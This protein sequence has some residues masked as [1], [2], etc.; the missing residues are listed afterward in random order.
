[1]LKLLDH[2]VCRTAKV[3]PRTD[4]GMLATWCYGLAWQQTAKC[5]LKSLLS[6]SHSGL[7]QTCAGTCR[8][9]G[10]KSLFTA[11]CVT[12]WRL[13]AAVLVHIAQS[14]PLCLHLVSRS[15]RVC[16]TGRCSLPCAD[17]LEDNKGFVCGSH[18]QNCIQI[19]QGI[20]EVIHTP[21]FMKICQ[22]F[23]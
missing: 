20:Y 8:T 16:A 22:Y 2:G 17:C 19:A 6:R 7:V 18:I 15:V 5:R 11:M 12:T 9:N 10:T 14:L 1:M 3:G 23:F 13:T 21:N 4:A